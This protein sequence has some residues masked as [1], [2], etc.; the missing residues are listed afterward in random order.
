MKEYVTLTTD[1]IR[2]EAITARFSRPSS[3]WNS[4]ARTLQDYA[5]QGWSTIAAAVLRDVSDD[6]CDESPRYEFILEREIP[7]S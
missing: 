4:G 5:E 3:I 1:D 7:L 2:F 6:G